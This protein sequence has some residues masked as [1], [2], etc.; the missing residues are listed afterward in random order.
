VQSLKQVLI[1]AGRAPI[2]WCRRPR[3]TY[4]LD[5]APYDQGNPSPVGPLARLVVSGAPMNMKAA[6]R[7]AAAATGKHQGSRKLPTVAR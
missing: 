1:A 4:A 2:C 6:A 7:I 3:G 5:A